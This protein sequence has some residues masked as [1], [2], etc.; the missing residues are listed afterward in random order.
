MENLH[1]TFGTDFGLSGLTQF[2]RYPLPPGA[3]AALGVVEA[4]A[5]EYEGAYA[6]QLLADVTVLLESA[7]SDEAIT[8]LW[9]AATRGHFDPA[10]HGLAGRAWLR[11]IASV[12]LARIR[13]DDP[14]F[15]PP[16]VEPVVD[17]GLRRAV[18]DEIRDAAPTLEGVVSNSPYADP[19]PGVVSALEAVAGT[20]PDLGFRLFLRA[21]QAYFVP[22]S[23]ARHD[24]FLALGQRFGY[25]ELVVD[26][27]CLNV[28]ADLTD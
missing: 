6:Y 23:E 14:S 4:K 17:E 11:R 15:E 8:T 16:A 2:I 7:M 5:G 25:H 19:L 18:R 22:I 27:G 1:H 12:C 20:D 10:A 9:L 13:Q 21:L 24:R 26:D 28:W 3:T